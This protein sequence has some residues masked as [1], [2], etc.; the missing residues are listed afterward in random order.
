MVP[1][2]AHVLDPVGTAPGVV[3]PGRPTVSCC[4]VRRVSCSHVAHSRPDRR[5]T[6]GDRR[7]YR[8][9]AGHLRMFGLPESGLAETLR[10]AQQQIG[11]FDALEITTCLRR[12]EVE[13][14][15]RYEPDAAGVYR[16]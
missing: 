4:P 15:T 16:S 11:G 7:P 6:R 10:D 3:V 2:G 13:I 8:I 9:S 12:G 1:A 14:V 5:G